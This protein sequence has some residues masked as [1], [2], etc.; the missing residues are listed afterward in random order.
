MHFASSRLYGVIFC[1][2]LQPCIRPLNCCIIFIV[3]LLRVFYSL[4]SV[5]PF[6]VLNLSSRPVKGSSS[7]CVGG[8]SLSSLDNLFKRLASPAPVVWGSLAAAFTGASLKLYKGKS[9]SARIQGLL[10]QSGT[11]NWD[12]KL[13]WWLLSSL[14]P[15]YASVAFQMI[16]YD[17]GF[18]KINSIIKDFCS[19]NELFRKWFW[20]TPH[21]IQPEYLLVSFQ[22]KENL[23]K[24]SINVKYIFLS[25][26][27][28]LTR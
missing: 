9:A 11:W 23:K 18:L 17:L 2:L 5:T 20:K 4:S 16:K 12:H 14:S 15:S 8:H 19:Y 1:P 13:L 10:L 7:F 25:S 27:P 6:S 28:F 21:W 26:L 3:V 22:S 24:Y